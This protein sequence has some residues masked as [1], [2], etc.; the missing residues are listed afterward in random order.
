[1]NG[2]DLYDN[3]NFSVTLVTSQTGPSMVEHGLVAQKNKSW[4]CNVV[5]GVDTLKGL[6]C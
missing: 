3:R 4:A 1:M 2:L 6:K 5:I